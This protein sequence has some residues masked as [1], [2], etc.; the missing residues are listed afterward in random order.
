M[1][2]SKFKEFQKKAAEGKIW[3]PHIEGSISMFFHYSHLPEIPSLV[4]DERHAVLM[5]CKI[6][7]YGEI[8]FKNSKILKKYLDF[9]WGKILIKSPKKKKIMS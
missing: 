2:E 4:F 9:G 7:K 8:R 6:P 1:D 5:P 3:N